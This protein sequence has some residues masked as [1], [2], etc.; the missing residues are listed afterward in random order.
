MLAYNIKIQTQTPHKNIMI[1]ILIVGMGP[2]N[3][4]IFGIWIDDLPFTFYALSEA[5]Y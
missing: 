1:N 2:E 3:I 4:N 5:L